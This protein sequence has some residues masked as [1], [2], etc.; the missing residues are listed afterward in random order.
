MAYYQSDEERLQTR[1]IAFEEGGIQRRLRLW[2]FAVVSP[3]GP[4]HGLW[5]VF[6]QNKAVVS[7]IELASWYQVPPMIAITGSNGKTKVGSW[8]H[9]CFLRAGRQM[10]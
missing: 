6:T 9:D 5:S 10:N 8:I 2:T 1:E 3:G 4:S 7:E